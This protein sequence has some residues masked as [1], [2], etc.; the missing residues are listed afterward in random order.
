MRR[1][2]AGRLV[3][4]VCG[5]FRRIPLLPSEVANDPRSSL[6]SNPGSW[7][8]QESSYHLTV[9]KANRHSGPGR[10]AHRNQSYISNDLH[11]LVGHLQNQQH[12]IGSY[13]QIRRVFKFS[14]H[15]RDCG[16]ALWNRPDLDP[17]ASFRPGCGASCAWVGTED[18]PMRPWKPT[19]HLTGCSS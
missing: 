3:P 9:S 16:A 4:P 8:Q 14:I 7:I 2:F 5:C 15:H 10:R 18:L 19:A 1:T 12:C 11:T 13:R 6:D 17:A